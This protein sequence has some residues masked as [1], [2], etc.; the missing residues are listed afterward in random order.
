MVSV[1]RQA[2]G[3]CLLERPGRKAAQVPAE[4]Y[5]QAVDLEAAAHI[6]GKVTTLKQSEAALTGSFK[7]ILRYYL[8]SALSKNPV[9]VLDVENMIAA[10]KPPREETEVQDLTLIGQ[11]PFDRAHAEVERRYA[12][13]GARMRPQDLVA[14]GCDPRLLPRAEGFLKP[15]KILWNRRCAMHMSSTACK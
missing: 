13:E 2:P 14:L 12:G 9:N 7:P 8:G 15:Q 3:D 5:P 6:V 4:C 11:S 10:T 1:L